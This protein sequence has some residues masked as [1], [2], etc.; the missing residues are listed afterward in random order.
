MNFCPRYPLCAVASVRPG[1]SLFTRLRCG[2]WSCEYCATKNQSIWR[3]HLSDILPQL[4]DHWWLVTLTAHSRMRSAQASLSN[5]RLNIGRLLKRLKRIFNHVRYVRVYEKHPSSV[6]RHIHL[7]MAGLS[8]YLAKE[9]SRTGSITF[10]PLLDRKA[11]RGTWTIKTW[12]KKSAQECG[13]GY[14]C[15]VQPIGA[16]GQGVNYVCKYLTKSQ[17]DLHEKGLRHVQTSRDIGA[18]KPESDL[19]WRVLSFITARDFSAGTTVIDLQTGEA[20]PPDYWGEF[21]VYPVENN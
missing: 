9:T 3:A 2:Q 12:F 20:I 10:I 17:Q 8:P 5:I 14:Q 21:D 18:P 13:M 19:K 1:L 6:A 4:S 7:I 11:H 16:A 15:D